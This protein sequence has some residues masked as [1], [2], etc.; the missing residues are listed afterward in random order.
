MFFL[1]VHFPFPFCC[2]VSVSKLVALEM[3]SSQTSGVLCVK[4][5]LYKLY[6]V[7]FNRPVLKKYVY[8]VEFGAT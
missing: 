2:C 4:S 7:E 8:Y 1:H 3:N 5:I 6:G